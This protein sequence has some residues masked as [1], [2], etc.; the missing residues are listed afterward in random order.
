MISDASALGLAGSADAWAKV[1]LTLH[2]TGQ[3]GDG[4]HLLDSLAVRVRVGDR[5]RV[6]PSDTLGL[7][8]DGPFAQGVPLDDR[9]L[10][11]R[12][13]RL[14]DGDAGR[15]VQLHLTKNLP[16]AAGIG[17]GSA[18]AAAALKL[19]AQHWGLPLPDDAHSLGADVPVCLHDMPQ[20]MTGVGEVLSPAP[21]L[22]L[23]WLVLVNPMKSVS[24]P[25]VFGRVQTKL[26]A[27]MPRVLPQLDTAPAF[28]AWLATQRNDLQ[29]AALEIVPEISDCLAAL[30]DALMARMSGSGATCFGLYETEALA[31]R[32]AVRVQQANPGWW[33]AAAPM[34]S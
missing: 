30:N 26:N 8:V 16:A 9:N 28:A 32:A 1:N 20:R 2:V 13:A 27:P 18:D 15:G 10:V 29:D 21:P 23:C 31:A 17:G 12:A 14:L 22:P 11:I 33:V 6:T 7:V 4:Y 24:T 5:L 34:I 25:Q 19:L 3:R